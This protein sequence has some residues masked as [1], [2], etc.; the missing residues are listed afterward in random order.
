MVFFVYKNIRG[1]SMLQVWTTV[2]HDDFL[3]VDTLRKKAVENF[4]KE[5]NFPVV[6]IHESWSRGGSYLRLVVY[7]Q[8]NSE[9]P[10]WKENK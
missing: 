10:R 8:D 9:Y 1:G 7:Y 6:S 5:I 2:V 3:S 4:N